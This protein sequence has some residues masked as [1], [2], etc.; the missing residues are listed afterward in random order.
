MASHTYKFNNSQQLQQD[1]IEQPRPRHPYAFCQ[2]AGEDCVEC[3]KEQ[4][5]VLKQELEDTKKSLATAQMVAIISLRENQEYR[6]EKL[7]IVQP[8]DVG[9][10]L[11]DSAPRN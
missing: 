1:S 2:C 3:L 5:D 7:G 11:R 9:A 8:I 4:I 10:M 6:E